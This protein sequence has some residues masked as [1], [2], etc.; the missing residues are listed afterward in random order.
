MFI[1]SARHKMDDEGRSF[2]RLETH[3]QVSDAAREY[4]GSTDSDI[5]HE[6]MYSAI[7]A[8]C[9]VSADI[10]THCID[11][12]SMHQGVKCV[13]E[14]PEDV[15]AGNASSRQRDGFHGH[16]VNC[17]TSVKCEEHRQKLNE[18][19]HVLPFMSTDH[20]TN[21]T[22]DANE[23]IQ[24]KLEKKEYPDG[25]DRIHEST[26]HWVVCPGGVLKEVKTEHTSDVSELLAVED[27]NEIMGCKL[28]TH[29]CTY[30]DNI[31]G[32]HN[33]GKGCTYSTRDVSPTQFRRHDNVLKVQERTNKRV[34]QG[35][36][37]SGTR[38]VHLSK[39][40]QHER[41]HTGVKPF[42][43]DTCGKSFPQSGYLRHHEITHSGVKPFTC[44]TCGK[45]FTSACNLKIHEII[46]TCVKPFTCD[47]CGKSFTQPGNLNRHEMTHTGV[48]PF[49]CDTCGKS[50]ARSGHLKNHKMTHTGRVKPFT[51]DTC[52]KSYTQ[53]GDLNRHGMTHAGVKPFTCDTCGKSFALSWHLK[54]H[55]MTH[56]GV[57]HFTCDTCGK[58]FARSGQLK[59]HKMTHVDIN[60]FTCDTCGKSFTHSSSLKGHE[61]THTGVKPFTCDTCGKSFAQSGNLT[62]HKMTHASSKLF[63]CDTCGKSF[64]QP[65]Y[66]KRHKRTHIHM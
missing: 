26:K 19:I 38:L 66:L 40:K 62:I 12:Y 27:C 4:S 20:E 51:C 49:T 63:T 14:R 2:V 16:M 56:T 47:T 22:N 23:T 52:G 6:R 15:H 5:K 1:S 50:F 59:N 48:K 39:L 44:D 45:S 3:L 8:D 53:Q 36:D 30:H 24:V 32:E 61:L 42:T 7:S 31:H 57:K 41:T 34:T 18:H 65:G 13:H 21:W 17:S 58:S 46:H 11:D 64:A 9:E 55:K 33:N 28:R 35:D 37:T 25:Y 10:P 54:S 29:T 43:C 60:P